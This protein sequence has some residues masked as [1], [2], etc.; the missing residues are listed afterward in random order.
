LAISACGAPSESSGP[1]SEHAVGV[2]SS[3]LGAD[4]TTS[5]L[6]VFVCNPSTAFYL[7]FDVTHPSTVQPSESFPVSV[8]VTFQYPLFTPYSGTF[9]STEELLAAAAT[10]PSQVLTLDTFHFPVGVMLH[11]LGTASATLTAGGVGA[12][13][14]LN[15]GAF[16][17]TITPDS[18]SPTNP[19]ITAHCVPPADQPSTLATI[20]IVQ[21]PANMDACKNDGWKSLTDDA[22]NPFKNQG[23][24]IAYTLR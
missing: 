20:P 17:Y 15:A 9:G 10:P 11:E 6:V 5:G 21:T 14:V 24:C 13:V 12:P 18:P 1:G 19:P 3:A 2:A 8:H 16:D 23:L 4:E 7:G 22:G